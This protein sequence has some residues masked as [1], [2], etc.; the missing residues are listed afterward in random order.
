MFAVRV[1]YIG[2]R[3][4]AKEQTWNDER[5]MWECSRENSKNETTR[6]YF[7]YCQNLTADM[8]STDPDCIYFRSHLVGLR[9]GIPGLPSGVFYSK[10]LVA[11]IISV[12]FLLS[13]AFSSCFSSITL[14]K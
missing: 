5:K 8:E 13:S 11:I 14:V 1:C 4:I 6:L 7:L 12:Q 10:S 9:R 3:L 2:E